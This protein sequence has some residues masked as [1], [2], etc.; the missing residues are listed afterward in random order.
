MT[1]DATVRR[2]ENNLMTI[3][4]GVIAFGVWS[5]VKFALSYLLLGDD[6][7]D[8]MAEEIKTAVV[9]IV[10]VYS[11]LNVL[12]YLWLGLS[13]RAEGRGKKKRLFYLIVIGIVATYSVFIIVLEL[14][15]LFT[16]FHAVT[17][18]VVAIIIDVTRMVF[19]IEIMASAAKLRVLRKEQLKKEAAQ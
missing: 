6:Y 4:T 7:W 17:E 2:L 15:S 14:A 3:G 1:I 16:Y 5:F 18:T 19:L 9:I 10:W 13:A 12:M 8:D 11:V